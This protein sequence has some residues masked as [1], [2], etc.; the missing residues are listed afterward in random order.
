MAAHDRKKQ[1]IAVA[2]IGYVGLSVAVLLAQNHH[3]FIT[4][5]LPEKVRQ[6]NAG[7]SPLRDGDIA[8]YLAEKKLDLTATLDPAEAYTGA[9]LILIAVPTDYDEEKD[10]LDTS[11]VEQVAAQAARYAPDGL[12]VIRS[13]VPVGYTRE[14]RRRTGGKNILFSPEFLRE[15]LAL[16]DNLYPSRIIVGTDLEDPRLVEAADTFAALLAEGAMARDVPRLVMADSEAEAVKLFSNTCL[17]MRVAFFNEL[18]TFAESR[19]LDSE[20]IIRGVCLDP[21]IGQGYNNPSFGYGGYCLPKDTKQLL[22]GYGTLPAHL[23]RA[24]VSSN[25][26]R[27]ELIAERVLERAGLLPGDSDE[28]PPPVIGVY[29][30]TMKSG[31]DNLR[32]SAVQGVM[33][34][35]TAGGARLIIYEPLLEDGSSFCGSEVVNRLPSFK[36]RCRIIVANRYDSCLD[37]VRDKVYTRDL[38][39][40][41]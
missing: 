25:Q 6:V 18:D 12:V 37:D 28:V 15:S 26:T 22:A 27:K 1:K 21:R 30:L 7:Q 9:D 19:G 38:F 31:S 16:H 2:G 5:L 8:R 36:E 10:R 17:A 35:L 3:V 4:D 11:A 39:R 14:L 29:R 13:T 41:N 24:V 32:H 34:R 23:I 20:R 40:Q 33:R